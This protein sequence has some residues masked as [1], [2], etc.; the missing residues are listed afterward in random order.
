MEK[1]RLPRSVKITID[2]QCGNGLNVSCKT[3]VMREIK[4]LQA[5]FVT[6]IYMI[7][8][9]AVVII[10]FWEFSATFP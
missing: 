3:V 6:K 7:I 2:T 10:N 4:R 9:T 5:A 8:F 1:S